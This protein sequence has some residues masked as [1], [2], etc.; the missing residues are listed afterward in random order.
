M[1]LAE[2]FADAQHRAKSLARRPSN[3]DLLDLYS[4]FKQGTVGDVTGKRPR[5]LDVKGRAMYDAWSRNRGI[6][7]AEAQREYVA[8]VDRLRG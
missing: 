4:L 5:I 8:L 7:M 6:S 3:Q 1:M 2:S